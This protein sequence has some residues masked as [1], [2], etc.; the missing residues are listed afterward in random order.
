MSPENELIIFN[1]WGQ[2]VFKENNYEN[3]WAGTNND[4]SGL[5][6]NQLATGTYYYI[7]R[8]INAVPIIGDREYRGYIYINR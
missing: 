6:S 2:I 7:F 3:D 4:S 1:R 5:F 8:T